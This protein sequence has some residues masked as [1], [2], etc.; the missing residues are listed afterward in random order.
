M[1]Q[2]PV[3]WQHWSGFTEVTSY[4]GWSFIAGLIWKMGLQP[5]PKVALGPQ[6]LLAQDS[7]Y[8]GFFRLPSLSDA[9]DMVCGPFWR[10]PVRFSP[11]FITE[12]CDCW[13]LTMKNT[14]MLLDV[15]V[16]AG[17]WFYFF[18][19]L[20]MNEKLFAL[21]CFSFPSYGTVR[22]DQTLF[23]QRL[24]I[25]ITHCWCNLSRYLLAGF[26]HCFHF[27]FSSGNTPIA[28]WGTH[29]DL[30]QNPQI[31]AKHGGKE[32]I[33]VSMAAELGISH[34]RGHVQGG[35]RGWLTA[36]EAYIIYHVH[37]R[38]CGFLFERLPHP[39]SVRSTGPKREQREVSWRVIQL[40]SMLLLLAQGY[41]SSHLA[42]V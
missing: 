2:D 33:N 29:L 19:L 36:L 25:Q 21:F 24:G 35:D 42:L 12:A 6:E 30:I 17:M 32:H 26:M 34:R 9:V 13:V 14:Q 18:L 39:L 10:A 27:F 4:L 28:V 3:P 22:C 16:L 20:R 8:K 23:N 5:P 37:K 31:R 11:L 38:G 7:I 40:L 41:L 1:V 15:A